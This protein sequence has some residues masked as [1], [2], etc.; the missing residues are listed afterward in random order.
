MTIRKDFLHEAKWIVESIREQDKALQQEEERLR[1]QLNE[2]EGKRS[3]FAQVDA[4]F[5]SYPLV[6]TEDPC[7]RCWLFDGVASKSRPAGH[8]E[9]DN[10]VFRCSHC[11]YEITVKV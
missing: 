2:I 9:N 7:P 6:K 3:N 10:D 4:R 5:N 1:E 8:D 11:D